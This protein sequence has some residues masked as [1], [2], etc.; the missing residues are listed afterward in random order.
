MDA[1]LAAGG[2]PSPLVVMTAVVE[3]DGDMMGSGLSPAPPG[4]NAEEVLLPMEQKAVEALPTSQ[5]P[6]SKIV[7]LE[8]DDSV[9]VGERLE[10]TIAN[11]IPDATV[12]D[13]GNDTAYGDTAGSAVDT[14]NDMDHDSHPAEVDQ[15]IPA[16]VPEEEEE[17]FQALQE[18]TETSATAEGGQHVVE[19]ASVEAAADPLPS[20]E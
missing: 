18:V 14:V 5:N 4:S 7:Y 8:T 20:A 9:M 11:L 19:A 12:N 10:M 6:S 17:P 13:D 16:A 3:G 2:D 15:F 1:T